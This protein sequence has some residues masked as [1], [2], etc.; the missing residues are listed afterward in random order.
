MS[1]LCRAETEHLRGQTGTLD[2]HNCGL[3]GLPAE[4]ARLAGPAIAT[5]DLSGNRLAALAAPDLAA[6][7]HTRDLRLGGKPGFFVWCTDY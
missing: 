7:C 6:L 1:K 3:V 2:V 5:V 4:L